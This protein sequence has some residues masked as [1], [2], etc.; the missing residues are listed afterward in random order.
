MFDAVLIENSDSGQEEALAI[1]GASPVVAVSRW[2]LGS[3]LRASLPKVPIP[4]LSRVIGLSERLGRWGTALWGGL[5]ARAR[6]S[7][8]WL[9]P[10]PESVSL[11]DAMAIRTGGYTAMRVMKLS[12]RRRLYTACSGFVRLRSHNVSSGIDATRLGALG[13]GYRFQPYR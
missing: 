12:R 2:C 11:R 9:V 5:A 3:I 7:G 8:D 1:T 13:V 6:V 4:P 10:L